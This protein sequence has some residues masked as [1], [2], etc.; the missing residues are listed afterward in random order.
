MRV[1]LG[2]AQKGKHIVRRILLPLLIVLV[3]LGLVLS[4][5]KGPI[6]MLLMARVLE[7]NATADP[8][9]A[10]PDGLHVTLCGAGGPLPDPKRS[11]PCVA[12]IAGSHVYLVDAGSASA[13]GLVRV[14]IQPGLIEGVFL[15][16]FHSDHIDG[17][18]ELGM[19]RW[20]GGTRKQPLP[21]YGAEGVAEVVQGFNQAYR[22]DAIYRSAHH[23]SEVAPPTGSGFRALTFPEP[24]LREGTVVLEEDGLRVTMFQVDHPPISPAVGYRF[25]YKGRSA[26]VSGDTSKSANLEHFAQGV[27]LLVHEALSPKLMGVIQGVAEKTGNETLATIAVDVLDHHA[28]PVE[29]AEIADAVGAGHLLYYHVVPPTPI[30]GLAS[31]F[32][33]GVSTAYDGPVTLGEDGTSI[34]LPAGSDR[35]AVR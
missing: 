23:G 9:A 34:S 29:A 8:I 11:G 1:S 6:S 17:L 22:L 16:H 10:R 30:P 24:G 12:V 14:G 27:D 25:D 4:F 28:S 5:F 35:I 7:R 21:V 31:V 19:L 32:L 13:R 26:L 18:G 2:L 33:E 3:G 15:T 20:T